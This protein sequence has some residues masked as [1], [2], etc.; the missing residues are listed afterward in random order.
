MGRGNEDKWAEKSQW[1]PCDRIWEIRHH[2]V[3]WVNW[4]L[5]PKLIWQTWL[6]F[7][8]C[9]K[10]FTAFAIDLTF[11]HMQLCYFLHGIG[12]HKDIFGDGKAFLFIFFHG[13]FS[14]FFCV[15]KNN[16]KNLHTLE[17]Y[18][19]QFFTS[20]QPDFW[21]KYQRKMFWKLS[22]FD[23]WERLWTFS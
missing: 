6:Q 21:S 8:D 15:R 13:R 2:D 9:L 3:A 17:E 5:F 4:K 16:H 14:S 11:A 10:A 1:T 22:R 19:T 20:I 18:L 23:D 12:I 7:T